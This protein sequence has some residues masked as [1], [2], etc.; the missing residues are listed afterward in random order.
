MMP[1][2]IVR[3]SIGSAI[4]LLTLL[5]TYSS[6]MACL[7]ELLV[8]LLLFMAELYQSLG[9][10]LTEIVLRRTILLS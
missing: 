5:V 6:P 8:I 4:H 2:N 10:L 3:A 1:E 9:I 7:P